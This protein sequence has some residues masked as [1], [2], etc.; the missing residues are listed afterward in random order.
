MRSETMLHFRE[1]LEKELKENILS[2]WMEYTPDRE[3][4]G[5]HGHID[6]LNQVVKGAGKGAV[7]NARI[8]WTFSAAYRMYNQPEYLETA[9]RAYAYIISYF[10]DKKYGG[11]YWEL[12]PDGSVRSSRKQIYATA[13]T[14]YGLAEYHMA[15]GDDRALKIAKGLFR[16]L[17]AKAFDLEFNG[18]TDA[19]SRDWKAL[20]DLRLSEKD[21]NESKT[22]NTHLHILEAYGNLFRIWKDPG[23]KEALKN[24]IK[25]FLEHFVDRERKVL[26]LF[27]DDNWNLKSTLISFGHDIECSWLLHEAA[28]LLGDPGLIKECAELAVNMAH[29][30]EAGQAGDGGLHYEFF[31]ESMELDS[32]KHW[33]PQAEAMVGYY[34]AFQLSGEQKFLERSLGSW[35]FIKKHLIDHKL[36][37]WF[38]S[39]DS[40][41]NPQT[42]KEKAG[43]WKCPY[44]NGR[45]CMELIHRI[46]S[47]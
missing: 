14:I 13:F 34:N 36:G 5:F 46:E 45:A 42:E 28:A 44:H 12:E 38:W 10:T 11:V 23:L 32:D 33:W 39:V 16:D 7:L 29:A 20:E 41:G 22:M 31:P 47:K 25:L 17:E 3:L 9:R 26:N 40:Q 4:G 15:C 37:E 21:Q 8:L 43:F 24:L 19:L 27:F 30:S 2:W 6:H 1:E 35:E 18:Y